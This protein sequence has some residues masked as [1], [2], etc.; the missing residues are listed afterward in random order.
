MNPIDTTASREILI[1]TLCTHIYKLLLHV[2][3]INF[4][5]KIDMISR[6]MIYVMVGMIQ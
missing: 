6:V 4:N 2:S 5:L 3:M 1:I